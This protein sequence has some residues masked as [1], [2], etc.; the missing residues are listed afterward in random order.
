MTDWKKR[1]GLIEIRRLRLSDREH[2]AKL[3]DGT[4]LR[5]TKE[6][7]IEHAVYRDLPEWEQHTVLAAAHG[8]TADRAVVSGIAAARLWNLAVRSTSPVVDLT[9]PGSKQRAPGKWPSNV[10][11]RSAFLGSDQFV[12]VGG[13][14]LTTRGRTVADITRWT[15][16]IDGVIAIDSLRHAYPDE[17]FVHLR[18]RAL[19]PAPFHGRG[20][21]RK[22]L[23]LSR[24]HIDSPLESWARMLLIEAGVGAT[25]ITQAKI[26]GPGGS[27]FYRVDLLIDGWLIIELDGEVK[28]D[29]STFGKSTEDVIRKE[30]KRE[31][32]LQNQGYVFLRCGKADLLAEGD[33]ECSLITQARNLIAARAARVPA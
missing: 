21:V 31:K 27:F 5:L 28:Y 30:R 4:Y 10:R 19:G 15:G 24:P 17:P 33:R 20:I 18:T 16:L 13:L 9:L 7:A 23:D 3:A 14:R 11:M 29:G 12:E 1:F 6:I 22:A 25:I 8:L 2:H 32:Y 26:P